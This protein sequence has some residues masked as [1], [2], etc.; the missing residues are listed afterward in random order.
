MHR[1][2]IGAEGTAPFSPTGGENREIM[3][4]KEGATRRLRHSRMGSSTAN[5]S[6]LLEST[7]ETPAQEVR[8]SGAPLKPSFGKSKSKD[9]SIEEAMAP[10]LSKPIAFGD[11]GV[12]TE[13]VPASYMQPT[14]ASL[15]AQNR[16]K[17]REREATANNQTSVE[18]KFGGMRRRAASRNNEFSSPIKRPGTATGQLNTTAGLS[19]Q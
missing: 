17:E 8:P 9:W 7:K 16:R 14:K 1:G 13:A 15:A 18:D 5:N 3:F 2:L 6:S 11:L 4:Q 12:I 10:K 19:T